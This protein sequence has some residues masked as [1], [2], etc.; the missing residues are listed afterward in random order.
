MKTRILVLHIFLCMLIWNLFYSYIDRRWYSI[1]VLLLISIPN[2]RSHLPGHAKN[3]ISCETKLLWISRELTDFNILQSN[4]FPNPLKFLSHQ[5]FCFCH[6]DLCMCK[7][8]GGG[9]GVSVCV[10]VC[11]CLCVCVN[12]PTHTYSEFDIHYLFEC[13]HWLICKVPWTLYYQTSY[14]FL[15]QQDYIVIRRHVGYC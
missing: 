11:P 8:R 15:I 3:N 9:G 2:P 13:V 1:A 14:S 4:P 6:I 7:I 10:S 5:L 12:I